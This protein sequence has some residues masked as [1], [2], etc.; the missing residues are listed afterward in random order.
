MLAYRVIIDGV[1]VACDDEMAALRL[2]KA[3]AAAARDSMS[4]ASSRGPGRPPKNGKSQRELRAAQERATALAFLRAVAEAGSTG[5]PSVG[6]VR[7]MTL[8]A[9]RGIGGALITV[10]RVL[11]ETG[12][13]EVKDVFVMRG[14]RGNRRWKGGAKI[15]DAI[16]KLSANGGAQ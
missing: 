4:G 16:T 6:V 10:K 14:H 5:L 3:V 8:K 1:E 15:S 7:A 11:R 9:P 13:S 12:F 2:A